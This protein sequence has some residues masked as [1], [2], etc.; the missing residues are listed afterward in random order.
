MK[1]PKF[2]ILATAVVVLCVVSCIKKL[3]QEPTPPASEATNFSEIKATESFSWSTTK[4]VNFSFNGSSSNDY[5][6]VLKITDADGGVL[7]QKL[8]K[9]SETYKVVLDVPAHYETLTVIYGSISEK[10]DCT[11]GS[12]AIT[13]D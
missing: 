4:K 6:L 9:A 10:I 12:V 8:Q 7:M 2:K 1:K 13:I 5:E 3:D 11:S